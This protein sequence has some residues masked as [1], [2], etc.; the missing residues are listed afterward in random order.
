MIKPI[1]SF[2]ALIHSLL[3]IS[4]VRFG[5]MPKLEREKLIADKEELS[6]NSKKRILDLRT[7]SDSIK[8]AFK[9][10]LSKTQL[11]S[12]SVNDNIPFQAKVCTL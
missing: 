8:T 4:A 11:I 3:P 9:D 2:S 12:E 10:T 6:T 1:S 7:L 5:R